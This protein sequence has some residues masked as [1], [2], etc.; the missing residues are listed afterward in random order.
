[1]ETLAAAQL[2][3]KELDDADYKGRQI[4]VNVAKAKKPYV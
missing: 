3:V 2:A 1:M 4:R